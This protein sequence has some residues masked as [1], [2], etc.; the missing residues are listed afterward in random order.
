MLQLQFEP[1]SMPADS[2]SATKAPIV[3]ATATGC[4]AA[5]VVTGAATTTTA[6][7]L[8]GAATTTTAGVL[9]ADAAAAGGSEFVVVGV[10]DGVV[11]EPRTAPVV[12]PWLVR[13]PWGVLDDSPG[14]QW[15]QIAMTVANANV[16]ARRMTRIRR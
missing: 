15:R 2:T 9:A 13:A 5:G 3:G 14:E 11:A 1:G 4:V 7:V 16:E 10:V 8:T 6:G 12:V